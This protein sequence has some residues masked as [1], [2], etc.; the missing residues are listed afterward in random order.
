MS[1][2]HLPVLAEF[3]RSLNPFW[4]AGISAGDGGTSSTL[5]YRKNVCRR[6]VA[7]ATVSGKK[8]DPKLWIQLTRNGMD[9]QVS[10][11]LI[12]IRWS[13]IYAVLLHKILI[14]Q[15]ATFPIDQGPDLGK[16][17]VGLGK[18]SNLVAWRSMV[19]S[20]VL[21]Y[22]S[23]TGLYCWSMVNHLNPRPSVQ[24]RIDK[25]GVNFDPLFTD[26]GVI[27]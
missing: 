7:D 26:L 3:R 27:W 8:T 17:W 25:E 14:H 11:L 4:T 9:H 23:I 10:T 6:G 21:L 18:L 1:C 16:N 24:S 5:A 12:C 15:C 2:F 22:D 19:I 13:S 20:C